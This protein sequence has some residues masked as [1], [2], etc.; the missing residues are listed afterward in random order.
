M[1]NSPVK[2][3]RFEVGDLVFRDDD[4]TH[5]GVGII[6]GRKVGRWAD[7][8]SWYVVFWSRCL[9]YDPMDTWRDD[10]LRPIP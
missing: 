7:G 5:Y 3:R 8:D 4:R 2:V 1:N 9:I 6:M 10:E